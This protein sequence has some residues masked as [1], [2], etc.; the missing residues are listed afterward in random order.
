MMRELLHTMLLGLVL[1]ACSTTE[2]SRSPVGPAPADPVA[3]LTALLGRYDSAAT[4]SVAVFR[5][6]ADELHEFPAV[7]RDSAI[8]SANDD[9]TAQLSANWE[10]DIYGNYRRFGIAFRRADAGTTYMA[11]FV[12]RGLDTSDLRL[13]YAYGR[14][15]SMWMPGSNTELRSF[16]AVLRITKY[17]RLR[18][19]VSG[20][21]AA[22]MRS[23]WSILG[24]WITVSGSFTDVAIE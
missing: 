20:V 10:D 13:T 16:K 3:G 15:P 1:V 19:T 22:E 21:F 2:E 5:T 11:G 14:P 18:R 9:G 6:S 24:K 4:G 17:D 23:H 8:I 7:Y 12:R